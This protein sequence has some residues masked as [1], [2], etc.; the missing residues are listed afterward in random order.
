MTYRETVLFA[1]SLDGDAWDVFTKLVRL[2]NM[3]DLRLYTLGVEDGC[4]YIVGSYTDDE[5]EGIEKFCEDSGIHIDDEEGK[6]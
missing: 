3:C 2:S 4:I 1:V 6:E 5:R